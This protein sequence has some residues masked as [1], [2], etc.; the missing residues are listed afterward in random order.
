MKEIRK[1]KSHGFVGKDG[2]RKCGEITKGRR[3]EEVRKA[4]FT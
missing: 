1:E 4:F 3:H 2:E